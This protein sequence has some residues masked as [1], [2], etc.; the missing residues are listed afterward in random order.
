MDMIS[1]RKSV[2]VEIAKSQGRV[3]VDEGPSVLEA[4]GGHVLELI[5][6]FVVPVRKDVV[7][8]HHECSGC[9]RAHNE[10]DEHR[11]DQGE[12]VPRGEVPGVSGCFHDAMPWLWLEA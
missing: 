7:S 8:A 2:I 6:P 10:H 3:T 5:G 12:P 9:Q 1:P 11:D 4:A